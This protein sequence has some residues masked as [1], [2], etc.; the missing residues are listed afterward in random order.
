MATALPGTS[1]SVAAPLRGVG[2]GKSP[3]C[4]GSRDAAR[5][6][7]EAVMLPV[8]TLCPASGGCPSEP[9]KPQAR[10]MHPWRL[11]PRCRVPLRTLQ[12]TGPYAGSAFYPLRPQPPAQ[13]P[14]GGE[15][16]SNR[17]S[18]V[19][20]S[21]GLTPRPTVAPSPS[22]AAAGMQPAPVGH[23][24]CPFLCHRVFLSRGLALFCGLFASL[25]KVT[26]SLL[27]SRCHPS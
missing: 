22:A 9:P 26:F 7:E 2:S 24:R 23:A 11:G 10:T 13:G 16:S 4:C 21:V 19:G 18:R 1:V 17:S 15:A 20:L 27:S 14:L 6:E 8:P 25:F 5:S 3:R 12:R